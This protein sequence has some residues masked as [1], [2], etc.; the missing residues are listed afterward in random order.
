MSLKSYLTSLIYTIRLIG[1]QDKKTYNV[2]ILDETYEGFN[3]EEPPLRIFKPTDKVVK[4]TCIMYP[5]ASPYAEEHPAMIMLGKII[6][7]LG[8]VVFIPRIPPLKNLNISSENIDWFKRAYSEIL[9]R[10]ETK[11]DNISILGLSYGG[12][13]L[14]KASMDEQFYS[15]RPKSIMIYGSPYDLDTCLEYLLSGKINVG[16]KS[17]NIKPNPWGII[18]LL[19]NYLGSINIGYDTS[20]MR[21]I[22]NHRIKD[23][24]DQ[25]ENLI[26]TLDTDKQ[27]TVRA[28]LNADRNE[29]IDRIVKIIVDQCKNQIK[30]ISPKEWCKEVDHKVF[31][32]HGAN[33]SMVPYTE[34]LSL[35]EDIKKSDLFISYLYEHKEISTNKGI[36]FKIKEINKMI[37]FFS[38]FFSYNGS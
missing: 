23:E 10:P 31:I 28:A 22:L 9:K 11:I 37:K 14:L 18:V 20:I 26:L 3:G 24:F 19:H 30:E 33:D 34:S 13:L 8:Y 17:Y 5:G 16:S 27:K 15:P 38:K 7:S 29:E 4:K 2:D 1:Y 35:Y 32:M 12:S 6:S 36:F 25:A 21:K